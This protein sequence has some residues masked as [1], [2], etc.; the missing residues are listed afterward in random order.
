MMAIYPDETL[1]NAVM[2][3]NVVCVARDLP[4]PSLEELLLELGISGVPVTD[5]DGRPVGMV[6][7]TDLVAAHRNGTVTDETRVADI[8]MPM[9]FCVGTE[10]TVAKTAGLMAFEG[11]HRVP[12]VDR[13]GRVVGLV[14]TLDVLRWLARASGYAIANRH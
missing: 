11:L 2:V 6:S 9:T 10:E 12:V 1:V 8:M 13:Q 14:S 3:R 5:A 4:V 7:K